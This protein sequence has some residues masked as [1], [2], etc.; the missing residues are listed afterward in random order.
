MFSIYLFFQELPPSNPRRDV[1]QAG[2][3]RHAAVLQLHIATTTEGRR[4]VGLGEAQGI[5]KAFEFRSLVVEDGE[6]KSIGKPVKA[7]GFLIKYK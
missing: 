1:S 2:E 3:H 6:G 4:V 7:H 5:P